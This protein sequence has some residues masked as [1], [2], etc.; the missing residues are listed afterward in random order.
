MSWL[1]LNMQIRE[2]DAAPVSDL[3][4]GWGALSSSIEPMPMPH[5]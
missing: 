2:C 3:F 5:A 1:S 4:L